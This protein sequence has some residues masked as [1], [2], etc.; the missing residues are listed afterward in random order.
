MQ[1]LQALSKGLR[2]TATMCSS[3]FVIHSFLCY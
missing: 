2:W 1:G 3:F